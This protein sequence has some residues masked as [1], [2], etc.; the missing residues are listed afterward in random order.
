Q[1]A[2]VIEYL[3]ELGRIFGL[4][5]RG[6]EETSRVEDI[7]GVGQVYGQAG[8]AQVREAEE[9]SINVVGGFVAEAI[10]QE[11]DV[12]IVQNVRPERDPGIIQELHPAIGLL[13][14]G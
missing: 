4:L 5:G 8:L 7:V 3:A 12:E 14:I 2:R 10:D 9:R 13:R 11:T 6:Y 1:P